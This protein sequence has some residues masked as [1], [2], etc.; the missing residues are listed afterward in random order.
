LI[1]GFSTPTVRAFIMASV[2]FISI[3]LRRHHAIWQLYGVALIL[4]LIHNPLSVFTR[5]HTQVRGISGSE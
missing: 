1:S 2:V 3:I 5:N 4:V